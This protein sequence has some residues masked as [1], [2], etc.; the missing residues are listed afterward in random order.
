MVRLLSDAEID[1]LLLTARFG[2]LGC[3][4]EGVTYVVPMGFAYD[5]QR[6]VGYTHEGQKVAMMRA[7]P[8]VCLQV[9][10][11]KSLTEWRSAVVWGRFEELREAQ[12]AVA[13]GYL[14]DR[15]GPIFQD[16][17]S[18]DRRGREITPPKADGRRRERV[19]FCVRITRRTGRAESP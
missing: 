9:E 10:E 13:V 15:Y 5:G 12:A 18:P 6:I 7:N 19:V 1:A 8:D 4:A 14:I 2:H 17:A 11:I 16:T 3:H